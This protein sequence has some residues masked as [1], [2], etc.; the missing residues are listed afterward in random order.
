MRSWSRISRTKWYKGYR[1]CRGSLS[2]KNSCCKSVCFAMGAGAIAGSPTAHLR[3][4]DLRAGDEL[5]QGSIRLKNSATY[6]CSAE[7]MAPLHNEA[8]EEGWRTSPSSCVL[9]KD[10]VLLRRTEHQVRGHVS[11]RQPQVLWFQDSLHQQRSI[12]GPSRREPV[13]GTA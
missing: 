7:G 9:Q 12:L 11:H 1:R 4:K 13:P 10:H 3:V 2:A 6:A 5:L 8:R